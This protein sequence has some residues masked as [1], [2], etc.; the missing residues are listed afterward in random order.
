MTRK[1]HRSLKRFNSILDKRAIQQHHIHFDFPIQR[2][3]ALLILRR[4]FRVKDSLLLG[5]GGKDLLLSLIQ[6]AFSNLIKHRSYRITYHS[7]EYGN[8]DQRLTDH[9]G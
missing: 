2:L 5:I 3:N 6:V 8:G 7:A 4:E 9:R 1:C